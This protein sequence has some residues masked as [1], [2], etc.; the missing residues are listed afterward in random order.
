SL[1]RISARSESSP[2]A[3]AGA[4]ASSSV[5]LTRVTFL[6]TTT[7]TVWRF[8]PPPTVSSC[9]RL[10]LRVILRGEAASPLPAPL[11]CVRRRK[12]SSFTFSVLVT[13]W[14]GSL[15]SMPASA[16]CSS[17]FSTGVFTRAASFRMV[18]CCDIRI[19]CP[20]RRRS[21]GAD[22][23]ILTVAGGMFRTLPRGLAREGPAAAGGPVSAPRFQAG[24]LLRPRGEDQ[25]RGA[26]LVQA[27]DAELEQ[28]V[29]AQVRQVLGGAHP[30]GGQRV[31]QDLVHALQRQQ[32]LGRRVLVQLLLERQGVV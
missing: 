10:R 12:P 20:G 31:G 11:P 25:R 14:S 24:D 8:L 15:N 7:S 32:V 23:S 3:T 30:V 9:L 18:V 29:G 17:S 13:T 19:P 28:F 21:A 1:R 16:S 27:I 4:A 6:R 2:A 5:G 26:L 22:V